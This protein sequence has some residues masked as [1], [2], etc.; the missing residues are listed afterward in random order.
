MCHIWR[1]ESAHR[2][3]LRSLTILHKTSDL[4]LLIASLYQTTSPI[5]II[6][7]KEDF[8]LYLESVCCVFK[9]VSCWRCFRSDV[10]LVAFVAKYCAA[11]GIA[12][13]LIKG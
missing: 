3:L 2:I 12:A 7:I 6:I 11:V 4:K 13:L 9:G 10:L 8:I 5:M 1:K